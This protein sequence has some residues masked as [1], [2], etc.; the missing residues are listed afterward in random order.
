MGAGH[1]Q[2]VDDPM[3]L[4]TLNDW[5]ERNQGIRLSDYVDDIEREF[6]QLERLGAKNRIIRP[7]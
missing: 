1:E 2:L 6:D 7:R 5:R 4:S 3:L